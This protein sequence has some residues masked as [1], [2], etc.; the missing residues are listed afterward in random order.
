MLSSRG[1]REL[2]NKMDLKSDDIDPKTLSQHYEDGAAEVRE[3]YVTPG[4]HSPVH[5]S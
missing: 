3:N 2:P 5:L 4:M 1:E